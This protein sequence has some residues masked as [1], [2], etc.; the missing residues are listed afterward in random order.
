MISLVPFH[1]F[2]LPS[3]ELTELSSENEFYSDLMWF[4]SC[5]IYYKLMFYIRLI[6]TLEG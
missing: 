1:L 4:F 2:F 5:S 6:N 3:S